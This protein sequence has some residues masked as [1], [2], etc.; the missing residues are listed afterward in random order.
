MID[1]SQESKFRKFH[2]TG[3]DWEFVDVLTLF[4][5]SSLSFIDVIKL[6]VFAPVSYIV[7]VMKLPAFSHWFFDVMKLCVF[8]TQPVQQAARQK[9]LP[10][11]QRFLVSWDLWEMQ[12][13][14]VVWILS[15]EKVTWQ[16]C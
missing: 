16:N 9:G 13:Q 8:C 15:E 1:Q 3:Q 4:F 7:D 2:F 10:A 6:Y 14:P 12:T 11:S 5:V